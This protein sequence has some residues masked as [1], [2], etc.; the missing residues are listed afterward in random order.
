LD[1]NWPVGETWLG[2]SVQVQY[3]K[4]PDCTDRGTPS[5][6]SELY[7]TIYIELDKGTVKW[8]DGVPHWDMFKA[9]R[10]VGE[11]R[12]L[13]VENDLHCSRCKGYGD[14]ATDELRAWEE[15]MPETPIPKGDGWQLWETVGDSPMSPVFATDT[16][17]V[18]WM[19]VNDWA[20]FGRR[21]N[22]ED[23]EHFVRAGYA[24]SFVVMVKAGETQIV[25]GVTATVQQ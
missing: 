9:V 8:P 4:C 5:G 22:R 1:F 15:A 6:Y 14:L 24:P 11:S 18:D 7:R 20:S 10:H 3:P 25:D 16:E 12:G 19:M 21:F 2:Y 13:S 17:L 23:T